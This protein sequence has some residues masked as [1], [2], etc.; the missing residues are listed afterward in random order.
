MGVRV[1]ARGLWRWRR[2]GC[3]GRPPLNG[4]VIPWHKQCRVAKQGAEG[5]R[6]LLCQKGFLG[7][8]SGGWRSRKWTLGTN[9]GGWSSRVPWVAAHVAQGQPHVIPW[10]MGCT[11]VQW[12]SRQCLSVGVKNLDSAKISRPASKPER[13]RDLQGP[14]AFRCME[15]H[16]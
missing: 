9:S 16:C 3:R 6:T 5:G 4:T 2:R 15:L 8:N 12:M 10:A 11:K 14:G 7:T 13:R 1:L